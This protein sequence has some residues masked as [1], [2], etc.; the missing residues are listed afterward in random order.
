MELSDRCGVDIPQAVLCSHN[1]ELIDYLGGDRGILLQREISGVTRAR[2]PGGK[3]TESGLK[4]SEIVAR[5]WE[6]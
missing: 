5:G 2:K 3:L 1:P 6:Q 4:L